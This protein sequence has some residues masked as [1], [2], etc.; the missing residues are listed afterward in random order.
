[1]SFCVLFLALKFNNKI[2]V[3]QQQSGSFKHIIQRHNGHQQ[4][5]ACLC[6]LNMTK[7]TKGILFDCDGFLSFS[8]DYESLFCVLFPHLKA[9]LVIIVSFQK[10]FCFTFALR[11][12]WTFIHPAWS[13]VT[14]RLRLKTCFL[15]PLL[16]ESHSL[17]LTIWVLSHTVRLLL[18]E[19]P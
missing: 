7:T 13:S 10:L 16:P 1:M 12:S 8:H 3:C 9:K 14:R 18:C 2:F 17:N 11:V 4:N 15:Q 6:N 5:E 19:N